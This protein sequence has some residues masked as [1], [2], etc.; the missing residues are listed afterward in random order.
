MS[1]SC[2]FAIGRRHRLADRDGKGD[3]QFPPG[4][5]FQERETDLLL[6]RLCF[7]TVWDNVA[8]APGGGGAHQ[9]GQP[10]NTTLACLDTLNLLPFRNVCGTSFS[11]SSKYVT[12]RVFTTFDTTFTKYGKRKKNKGIKHLLQEHSKNSVDVFCAYICATLCCV[13]LVTFLLWVGGK[14]TL[15]SSRFLLKGFGAASNQRGCTV[16]ACTQGSKV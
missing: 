4:F 13:A 16:V 3:I 11:V 12:P 14:Y 7:T 10:I 9:K 15:L 5:S 6:G 2:K 1:G 8:G